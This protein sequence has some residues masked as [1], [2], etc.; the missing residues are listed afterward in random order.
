MKLDV[1]FTADKIIQEKIE[2]KTAVVIDVLRATS[3][4]VTALA[5]GCD[6]LLPVVSIT[7]AKELAS[8]LNKSYLVAG[9]RGGIKIDE[10]DLGNSPCD[11][12]R[13]K[14]KDKTIVLTTT[15]GTRCFDKLN[16]AQEV[17][18]ASLLNLK[19]VVAQLT[20]E[21]EIVFCCAG[22]Q[23]EFALDDFLTAG[24]AIADLTTNKQVELSDS[25]Q[26]AYDFYRYNQTRVLDVL[27][28]SASGQNLIRLD[29]EEDIEF[30]ASENDLNIVPI[31]Q[32]NKIKIK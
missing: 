8:K 30:I 1:I 2:G 4:I 12:K 6:Q 9:E 7:E 11:Y 10:F 18:I 29:K 3:T 32:N 31:Y 26:T 5:N 17:I 16:L 20:Q 15:N 23:G 13:D 27:K 25:A 22:V 24:K 19:S 14:I 28:G 21:E